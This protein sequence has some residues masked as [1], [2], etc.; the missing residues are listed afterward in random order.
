[1]AYD[2]K[3][4]FK[5]A[6]PLWQAGGHSFETLAADKTLT[7]ADAQ[8]LALDAGGGHRNVDLPAPRKGASFWIANRS[9]AAENLVI[10]QAD[11]STTLATLNQ[12]ESGMF[13]CSADAEDDANDGWTLFVIFDTKNL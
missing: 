9:D 4:P 6:R 12:N 11:A 8:Y 1:M 3:N 7:H 5:V 10:R 13:F 2:G